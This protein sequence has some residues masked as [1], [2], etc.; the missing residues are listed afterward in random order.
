M[1]EHQLLAAPP[2][3][4]RLSPS[5]SKRW[6][7][8][9]GSLVLESAYPNQSSEYTDDGV[10]MHYIASLCLTEH[11]QASRHIGNQVP[12]H[13]PGELTRT[14]LFTP[15]MAEL[16]Q[17]Y[18]DTVRFLGIGNVMLIEHR[19]DFTPYLFGTPEDPEAEAVTERQFGT[20]DA[21]ILHELDETPGL[22]ELIVIDLK[23]GWVKV[24]PENNTQAMF[25]ALG[26]IREFAFSHEIV[27]ARI[28][29]YQPQHGGLR[30][31]VLPVGDL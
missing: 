28:G 22:F 4:A 2:A 3:H 11:H 7:T 19:V 26:A 5:G 8:C 18:V 24:D 25:Y 14:V 23:T 31:W 1:T 20:A 16:T 10:A 12:V 6:L 13:A 29:I 21:I 15:E 9:P 17:G 30:E 27:Q